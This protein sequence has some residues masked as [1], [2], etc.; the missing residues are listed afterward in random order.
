MARQAELIVIGTVHTIGPFQDDASTPQPRIQY[1]DAII[2]VDEFV[3]GHTTS[4]ELTLRLSSYREEGSFSPGERFLVF[5]EPYQRPISG[6]G[7]AGVY[8][9]VGL[10]Q[11]KYSFTADGRGVRQYLMPPDE[12]DLPL[13]AFLR[14]VRSAMALGALPTPPSGLRPT[15]TAAPPS[16]TDGTAAFPRPDQAVVSMYGDYRRIVLGPGALRLTE[17]ARSVGQLLAGEVEPS[18]LDIAPPLLEHQKRRGQLVELAFP[19]GTTLT[20]GGRSWPVDRLLI[21][22]SSPLSHDALV[23]LGNGGAYDASPLRAEDQVAR[24]HLSTLLSELSHVT[25]SGTVVGV[26]RGG[27]E[28]ALVSEKLGLISVRLESRPTEPSGEIAEPQVGQFVG[29]DG[30]PDPE[31]AGVIHTKSIQLWSSPGVTRGTKRAQMDSKP[32]LVEYQGRLYVSEAG[33]A[34]ALERY[35]VP[36]GE[37]VAPGGRTNYGVG[38]EIFRLKGDSAGAAI[39]LRLQGTPEER[40][41]SNL[42]LRSF[43][44]VAKTEAFQPA[45]TLEH[46]APLGAGQVPI[47]LEPTYGIDPPD[48]YRIAYGG[49]VYRPG[50]FVEGVDIEDLDLLERVDSTYSESAFAL[51]EVYRRKGAAADS[52]LLLNLV[53]KPQLADYELWQYWKLAG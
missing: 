26:E 11:G 47:F 22:A 45:N 1:R 16:T 53:R 39:V 34:K 29:F 6:E 46:P 17:L 18:D 13:D 14:F 50:V 8:R 23:F 15:P 27:Q 28:L 20:L 5:L 43:A 51:V 7:V 3:K 9:V 37:R 4:R 48:G 12:A 33:A 35:L 41:A 30:W 32:P 52:E 10:A 36:T 40:R 42:R 2:S 24:S 49:S 21:S 31:E 19:D 25:V 38:A 44:F